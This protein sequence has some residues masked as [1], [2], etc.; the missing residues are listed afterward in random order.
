MNRQLLRLILLVAVFG[1]LVTPGYAQSQLVGLRAADFELTGI[2]SRTY[3]LS[4]LQGK[5]VAVLVFYRGVW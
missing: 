3:R 2:D 1:V 5:S 4:D